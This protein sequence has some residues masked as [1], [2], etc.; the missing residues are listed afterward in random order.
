MRVGGSGVL[1]TGE[2]KGVDSGTRVVGGALVGVY[3]AGSGVTVRSGDMVGAGPAASGDRVG[4]IVGSGVAV[5][6]GCVA[7][8]VGDGVLS[9][10]VTAS[11]IAPC[12]V[13]RG[14]G[15]ALTRIQVPHPTPL[16]IISPPNISMLFE[17]TASILDIE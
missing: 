3:V 8:G 1:G 9:G 17:T 2:G 10:A 11:T 6:G 14:G 15:G 7:R 4:R 5:A 13:I 12:S 16:R